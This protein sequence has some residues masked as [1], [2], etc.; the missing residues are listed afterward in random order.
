MFMVEVSALF[1]CLMT[2]TGGFNTFLN[3]DGIF[4][5]GKNVAGTK[6]QAYRTR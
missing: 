2:E 3:V 6:R 5:Q 1:S 4:I